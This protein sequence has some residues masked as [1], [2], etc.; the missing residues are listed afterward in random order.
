MREASLQLLEQG[1]K[2]LAEN[3]KE[4]FV[5]TVTKKYYT[6]TSNENFCS[7]NRIAYTAVI[8]NDAINDNT[9]QMTYDSSTGV[10]PVVPGRKMYPR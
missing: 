6:Y 8:V 2:T 4:V 3:A 10:F 5:D 1:A 9:L 7:I